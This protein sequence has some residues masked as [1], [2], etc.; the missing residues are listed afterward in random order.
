[1]SEGGHYE[2]LV[3]GR[4]VRLLKHPR[5]APLPTERQQ[6]V[7]VAR[8]SDIHL[9]QV[10]NRTDADFHLLADAEP[11][12]A[13]LLRPSAVARAPPAR[14]RGNYKV[15]HRGLLARAD[16]R[17]PVLVEHRVGLAPCGQRGDGQPDAPDEHV[18]SEAV[19]VEEVKGQRLH[20]PP[21]RRR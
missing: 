4:V 10:P 9:G 2:A 12:A 17:A 18:A 6:H 13:A 8:A 3:E 11:R 14:L 20:S 7:R 1:M 21:A 19:P 5:L 16:Q 15:Q